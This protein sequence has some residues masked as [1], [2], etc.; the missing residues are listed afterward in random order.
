M[1][2][3][4]F[5]Q[6]KNKGKLFLVAK[7]SGQFLARMPL[8]MGYQPLNTLRTHHL[9]PK[10]K[11]TTFQSRCVVYKVNCLDCY[12][13]Y[14]GQTDRALDTRIKE[15]REAVHVC[16]SK[17]KIAQH[18]SKFGHS[19]DFDHTAIIDK[20]RGYQKRHF[21]EAWHSQRD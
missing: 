1:C 2:T 11:L 13:V 14:Y 6:T 8:K 10:N 20:A 16:D 17:S 18:T 21:L 7:S 15:H 4:P 9:R 5:S 19:M 3:K 12:F